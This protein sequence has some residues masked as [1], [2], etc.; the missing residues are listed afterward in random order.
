MLKNFFKLSH[1]P[2]VRIRG[3]FCCSTALLLYCSTFSFHFSRFYGFFH[4]SR[5]HASRFHDF[6]LDTDNGH[7]SR[8]HAFTLHGI[9]GRCRCYPLNCFHIHLM[10]FP[11]SFGLMMTFPNCFQFHLD[12]LIKE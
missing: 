8:F 12:Y 1:F 6:F 11:R 2:K 5:L 3:I 10:Q 9:M 4:A 7:G